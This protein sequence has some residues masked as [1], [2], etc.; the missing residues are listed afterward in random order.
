MRNQILLLIL[1]SVLLR[2][3]PENQQRFNVSGTVVNSLTN[4]PVAKA[5]VQA[6]EKMAMSDAE[7]HF[8]IDGVAGPNVTMSAR[9]PGFD[10]NSQLNRK[11]DSNLQDMKLKLVPLAKISGRVLDHEGEPV[12]GVGV[13]CIWQQ[14]INGRKQWQPRGSVVTDESGSYL[15]EDLSPGAYLLTTRERQVYVTQPKTE[16]ARFVY[17]ATYYP[18]AP[19]RDLAQRVTLTPGAEMKADISVKAIRGARITVA[20]VPASNNVMAT[21]GGPDEVFG[22]N[23]AAGKAGELVFAAVPPGTW[24]ITAQGPFDPGRGQLNEPPM[25]G[26]MQVDVGTA[27]IDN[28]KLTLNK[29]ADIPVTVSGV[30]NATVFLNLVSKAGRMVNGTS[31]EPGAGLVIRGVS[32][33]SYRVV[34]RPAGENC[35]TSMMSGSADLLH[36]DLVVSPGGSV[37]AIQ[38]VMSSNCAQLTVKTSGDKAAMAIVTSENTEFEPRVTLPNAAAGGVVKGLT[39]GDYKVCAFDDIGGLEYANPD[40]LSG[41]K[42][43]AVHLEAGQKATVQ[44]EVNE[45]RAP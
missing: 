2:G 12:E 11:L 7:G 5:L 29:T 3:Q 19:S 9:R 43:Q 34:A 20:T 28:L 41:F 30:E 25:Y 26:E 24:T 42:C 6:N 8:E 45:R 10:G 37:P 17:P 23:S 31:Q 38:V 21:I 33:G 36:D 13:Q 22:G 40:A 4:E 14:I 27:D 18:D 44:L 15:I 16:A 39:E 35:V 1:A 32:P